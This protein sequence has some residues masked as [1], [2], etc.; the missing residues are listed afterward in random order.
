MLICLARQY[1]LYYIFYSIANFLFLFYAKKPKLCRFLTSF[2]LFSYYFAYFFLSQGTAMFYGVTFMVASFVYWSGIL[3]VSSVTS[4]SVLSMSAAK[5]G[6]SFPSS[7]K[8]IT[9]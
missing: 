8:N 2:W 9:N 6:F 4:T 5:Y 1:L 3:S 7:F